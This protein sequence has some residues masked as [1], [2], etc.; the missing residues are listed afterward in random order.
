MV[1]AGARGVAEEAEIEI[2]DG[3][4]SAA[5]ELPLAAAL[6]EA[7]KDPALRPRLDELFAA[8]TEL[9]RDQRH[10]MAQQFSVEFGVKKLERWSKRAKLLLQGMTIA[11]GAFA[12]VSVGYI[13]WQA[14]EASG[15]IINA[16][17]APPAFAERGLT[18]KVLA[19]KL[20][21]DLI[22]LQNETA[23]YDA[24]DR[25]RGAE[26]G[27]IKMEVPETGVTLGEIQ[28]I[29]ERVLSRETPVTGAIT[30]PAADGP[31][32]AMNLRVGEEAGEPL[33]QP[34]GDVD[35][36]VQKA[37]E[38]IYE[39]A[40]PI[41]F[42]EWLNQHGRGEEGTALLRKVSQT[43]SAYLKAEALWR[44]AADLPPEQAVVLLRRARALAPN[45]PAAMVNFAGLELNALFDEE[46][47]LRDFRLGAKLYD[48]DP[49]RYAGIRT[50]R[51]NGT[52]TLG[53][54]RAALAVWCADYHLS[55]CSSDA[56]AEAAATSDPDSFA[57]DRVKDSRKASLVSMLIHLHD[58]QSA[59]RVFAA[60][61]P[62]LTAR[63]EGY[64]RN[65][66]RGWRRAAMD[67]D[68]GGGDWPALLKDSE[69]GLPLMLSPAQAQQYE[70]L[71]LA[72][73]GRFAE[74]E[75]TIALTPL[76]CNICLVVRGQIAALKGDARG[77]DAWFA[78]AIK[79]A[80]SLPMAEA[81]WARALLG[82]GDPAGAIAKAQAAHDKSPGFSDPLEVWGEALLAKGDPSGASAK[83][84]EAAKLTPRW[85]RLHLKWAEAL[86]RQG[87]ADQARTQKQAAAAED[88]TPAERAELSGLK[89]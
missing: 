42:A 48:A 26:A 68:W 23:N 3:A 8:Q 79:D 21:D 1:L 24:G 5:S 32:L 57:H 36:L 14:H 29:M 6:D 4:P 17:D 45:N 20:Q 83:F 59:A 19:A 9:L 53:D 81:E 13:A 25:V 88:L 15:L 84:A 71:A 52:S 67:R 43:G 22:R 65:V 33:L 35:A 28:G 55:P 61:R 34:D 89:I 76:A 78:A 40:D 41:R 30:R 31:A 82:R 18:P 66:E 12:L 62:D 64:R 11:I 54:Y 74:A 56:L 77:A 2:P 7:A 60:P 10:H 87:K 85:G 39:N 37:A 73:L 63:S 44:L 69:D 27:E 51:V 47:A 72:H 46:S 70:A 49:A 50:P 58:T 38:R 80:P 86:A 75:R 16:I